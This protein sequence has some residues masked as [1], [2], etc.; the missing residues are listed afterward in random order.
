MG[1]RKVSL[2]EV[3]LVAFT[4]T[5]IA[6]LEFVAILKGIDGRTLAVAI[7]AIALLAPSPVGWIL[8]AGNIQIQRVGGEK[9]DASLQ[10]RKD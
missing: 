7:A 9:T 6:A 10:G 3:M 4:I 2:A 5:I 1:G 8:K